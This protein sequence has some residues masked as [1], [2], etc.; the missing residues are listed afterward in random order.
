[1]FTRDFEDVIA[2]WATKTTISRA[3]R[4]IGV[5]SESGEG[6][7]TRLAQI[8]DHHGRRAADPSASGSVSVRA[9]DRRSSE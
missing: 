1:V 9:D 4:K 7:S 5:L 6:N 3:P 8:S 2:S